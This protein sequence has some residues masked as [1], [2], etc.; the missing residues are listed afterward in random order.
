MHARQDPHNT[1]AMTLSL[2]S[3]HPP[4]A[5][6]AL[7]PRQSGAVAHDGAGTQLR[8]LPWPAARW[9]VTSGAL[10]AA[11]WAATCAAVIVGS[12]LGRGGVVQIVLAATMVIFAVGE[13]LLS[14]S[15]PAIVD[16]PAP[17]AVAGLHNRPGILAFATGCMLGPAAGGA[18]LGA[19]WATSLLTTAAAACALASIATHRLGR[20]RQ[21]T[22]A[23]RSVRIA[24]RQV[25]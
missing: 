21:L 20:H 19:G 18:A 4:A 2:L 6:R 3:I 22:S 24:H 17:P 23:P 11:A 9:R 8:A 10:A 7:D 5:A 15:L 12:H 13:S 1:P 25:G 14:P 16:D